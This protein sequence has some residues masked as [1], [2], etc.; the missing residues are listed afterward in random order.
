MTDYL[1]EVDYCLTLPQPETKRIPLKDTDGWHLMYIE[2]PYD[3]PATYAVVLE[4]DQ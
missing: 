1:D 4:D 2:V 3:T